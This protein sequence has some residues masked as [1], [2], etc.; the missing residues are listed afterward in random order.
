MHYT[1]LTLNTHIALDS[2]A[3]AAKVV[4]PNSK[5]GVL[6]HRGN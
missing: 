1:L 2:A 3:A 4:L 5:G 6:L